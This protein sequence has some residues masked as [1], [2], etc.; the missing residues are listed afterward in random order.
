MSAD[1]TKN[2][3][4]SAS[5]TLSTKILGNGSPAPSLSAVTLLVNS[6]SRATICHG[7]QHKPSQIVASH[8]WL[9]VCLV[10]LLPRTTPFLVMQ[11]CAKLLPFDH[12][13]RQRF[14]ESCALQMNRHHLLQF[15]RT[16][17]PKLRHWLSPSSSNSCQ[18]ANS[19]TFDA[20]STPTSAHSILTL[21]VLVFLDSWDSPDSF[22]IW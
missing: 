7:V 19:S 15:Y 22:L 1:N 10:Q 18:F 3:H 20:N 5:G 8:A 17:S 6:N 16:L 14:L 21:H 12:D 2:L 9:S 11:Q 13:D 4:G